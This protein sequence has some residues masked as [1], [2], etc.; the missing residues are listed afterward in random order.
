MDE[1]R[2]VGVSYAPTVI[3]LEAS[4]EPLK[5]YEKDGVVTLR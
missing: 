5:A 2:F 3:V 1:I 4:R